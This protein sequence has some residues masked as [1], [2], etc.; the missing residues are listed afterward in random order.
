MSIDELYAPVAHQQHNCPVCETEEG[1]NMKSLRLDTSTT[2][3]EQVAQGGVLL[4]AVGVALAL[5]W[6]IGFGVVAGLVGLVM[7]LGG[8]YAS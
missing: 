1:E 8:K 5:L 7:V 2:L 3:K 4:I 6:S